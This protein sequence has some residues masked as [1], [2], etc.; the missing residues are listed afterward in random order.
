M[1]SHRHQV[2]R[3]LTSLRFF[4]KTLWTIFFQA[5]N[6]TTVLS[7]AQWG[8]VEDT[9]RRQTGGI[10]TSASLSHED[11]VLHTTPLGFPLQWLKSFKNS[12]KPSSRKAELWL[13]RWNE[14]TEPS[15]TSGVRLAWSV[16]SFVCLFVG[17]LFV[18]L[19]SWGLCIHASHSQRLSGLF[20]ALVLLSRS[21]WTFLLLFIF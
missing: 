20:V 3:L 18:C 2:H 19:S 7:L 4:P 17:C 14:H 9:E 15:T 5:K 21:Y 16:S 1:F 6:C 8:R 10:L 12:E 11:F 13:A